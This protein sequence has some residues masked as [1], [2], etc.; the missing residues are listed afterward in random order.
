M[1]SADDP[2]SLI[3]FGASGDLTRRKLLP[4]LFALYAT[5]TLPEPFAIVAVARTEMSHDEF[6]RRMREAIRDH[7]RVQPPS[8][9]V[10][11]RF[12]RAL[13][14]ATGD[15]KDFSLYTGL[16]AS[17][18][19]IEHRRGGSANRLFYCATPP[20]L[21]DDIVENLGNSG[22]AQNGDGWTRIVVEKPFGHD[23]DS[24]RALNRQLRRYFGEE[25]IYRIDHYLG[26]ETVQNLLV[27]RFANE[28]YEPL[29]NRNHV[30]NVQIT[31]AESIGVET[32]G[33]YYEESGALRDMVQNHL[34]QLLC[35]IAM[36]PPVTFD[37]APVR[38]EKNKV[39]TAIRPLDVNRI[40]EATLRAQYGPGFADGRPVVGYRQ[41][42]GVPPDSRTET[43]VALK[44]FVD[45]WRWASVPFY[46]RTGKRLAK[47]ASEIAIQFRR[48]PH[49][50]FRRH[51]NGVEPNT[52]LI[53]IQP[54][55]GLALTIAAKVPGPDLQLGVV[56]LDF[57]YGQVFGGQSP[58]AY[59]RLLLDAI[60]GDATL[61]A[62]GD[63]VEQAWE[64]LDPVLRAWARDT[65][66]PIPTYE[67]GSWGPREADAFVTSDGYPWRNP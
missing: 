7:G 20:S 5:R 4:A 37:A 48:T 55:E 13:H 67:A 27:L 66:S 57:Q 2:F 22:L 40:G 24:A 64:I 52:L 50:I 43:Y 32:R 25:Q 45:N 16:K 14:Y 31:V 35:L 28:I 9:H 6:R 30:A 8:E 10:W 63:W 12:S 51:P 34:L 54:D 39:L 29:W 59:E 62:R 47:R 38:D 26:K 58:E 18:T 53:R 19:D 17:L 56:K 11:E 44:L 65:S 21:Y 41:E 33:A 1:P 49:M 60:H 15:P 23:V 42:R 36:E 3:I 61:Y 46:L